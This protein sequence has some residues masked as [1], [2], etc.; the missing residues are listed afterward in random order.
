MKL[1]DKVLY[2]N[3]LYEILYVY[4]NGMFEIKKIEMLHKVELV[5]EDDIVYY[6]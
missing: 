5:Y 2:K 6:V 1:G 4:D 3:D